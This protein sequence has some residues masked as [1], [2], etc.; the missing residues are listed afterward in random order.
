MAKR[1]RNEVGKNLKNLRADFLKEQQE[2]HK[3]EPKKFWKTVSAIIPDKKS[4]SGEIWLKN[5]DGMPIENSKEVAEFFN[6]FFS[7]IGRE[8]AKNYKEEWGYYG[9]RIADE[10][11]NFE[12]NVDEVIELC[13]DIN[14]YKSSGMDGLSSR[15]CK[16][17]F[18]VLS[19][20]LTHLF[21]CS[22]STAI[23]PDAWKAAKVVPLFKGGDRE[24]VNN[25]R[26][27]S[28][29]PLPGKLL[30]RVVHKKVSAFLEDNKFLCEFQGGFRKGYSTT[31][32]IADLTDDLFQAI[33]DC[34][35]TLAAFIDLRKAFDTVD[36]EILRKK[37]F[38]AGIRGRVL[39]W[40]GNY[41]SN[42]YQ[43]TTVNNTVSDALPVTCG[44]PQGSVLGPLFFLIYINDLIYAL[45][46]CKLK[47]YADDTVIYHSDVDHS[48]ASRKLQSNLDG[49]YKWCLE[50]KLTVNIKK[51]KV[52]VF[53]TRYRVKKAHKS[54]KITINNRK[55][56]MVP[57]FRYLGILLDSTLSYRQ[58][59]SSVIRTVLHKVTLLSKVK[60]Y[61]NNDVAL[62]IYKS[63]ILPYIDYADVIFAKSGV[64]EL[65]KLQR[66]QNR[67][68]KICSSR[69]KLYST[70][71]VHKSSSV[72][73]LVDR[74]KAHV[75]NFMYKRQT[76][77]DLLNVR[78]IRTRAHDA[79]LFNVTVP[80]CETFKRSIG[81]FGSVAWNSLPPALRNT[82][83]YLAFKYL[84]KKSM[85]E[86]L[87]LIPNQ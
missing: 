8:L 26:P 14:L 69:D 51:T 49:F 72:P 5:E 54:V 75:L 24:D 15:I 18:L 39:D 17:A 78:E 56:Q 50:N 64:T 77:K 40:C 65:N 84:Q 4:R 25:Y 28:L 7:S 31:S 29:L 53:G 21:N 71:A 30:E 41:L 43:R 22:L 12:T 46:D 67:C 3:S 81:Y 9:E 2:A 60:R 13:R 11:Q 6:N 73:F 44:V 63:M 34:N 47:L 1:V 35:V 19:D 76:R 57:S 79:P 58:H 83:S 36:L 48:L 16:D 32:T 66:L 59:I 37:L 27:V 70:D 55:L 45:D 61:L 74:R 23:F 82:N 86:P 80:R 68:L 62:Q 52:M 42:R 10:M 38:E 20:Q 87:S 33:N 85:L